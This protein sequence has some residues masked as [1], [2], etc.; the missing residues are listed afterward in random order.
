VLEV[1]NSQNLP[2]SGQIWG[3]LTPAMVNDIFELDK[4]TDEEKAQLAI[5][6]TGQIGTI[7]GFKFIMRYNSTLGHT[8]VFY[9][10]T[11]T[12]VKKALGAAVAA[13]DNAASI[14]WH[15]SMVRH[16]EGH[17][18][19]FID[20]DNPLYLGTLMN[21]KVRF[22]AAISRDDE[23]GVVTLVESNE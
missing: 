11:G 5:V 14:F 3:L 23:K 1:F 10:N 19:T 7:F 2:A 16:A 20:R 18:K 13:T 15:E 21:N 17:A 8:G 4:L 12:P 9:D 22:G 6:R